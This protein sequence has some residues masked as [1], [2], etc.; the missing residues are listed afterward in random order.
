MERMSPA[1]VPGPGNLE[2][3][4]VMGHSVRQWEVAYNPTLMRERC[5]QAVVGMDIWRAG[6]LAGVAG[7]SSPQQ[8]S[9]P[10]QSA[11]GAADANQAAG[12]LTTWRQALLIAGD[13]PDA[14][15]ASPAEAQGMLHG[16]MQQPA[17]ALAA[18]PSAMEHGLPPEPDLPHHE[19]E[20][21]TSPGA[22]GPSQATD[23]L[24]CQPGGDLPA[25]CE[26]SPDPVA[27][28]PLM[29]MMPGYS[30]LAPALPSALASAQH[31][32]L[33]LSMMPS[34]HQAQAPT[35]PVDNLPPPVNGAETDDDDDIF[36]DIIES[37][38]E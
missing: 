3:A 20:Q 21:P 4:A 9:G 12:L 5:Q 1:R 15:P 16:P 29:S 35:G 30:G 7:P 31:T 32:N 13:I 28:S 23:H 14:E 25:S 22:A 18:S 24:A 27:A 6:M 34:T 17:S 26:V 37:D 33:L 36:F 38:Q 8:A 2:A 10:M 11:A 19:R